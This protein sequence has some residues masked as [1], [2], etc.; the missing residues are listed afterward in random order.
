MKIVITANLRTGASVFLLLLA[1]CAAAQETAIDTTHL[2]H[3]DTIADSLRTPIVPIPFVGSIERRPLYLITDSTLNFFDYNSAGDLLNVVPGLFRY[4]LGSPG[5]LHGLTIDGLDNRNIAFMSDGILLNEP[6]TGTFNPY[7]YPT[8]NAERVEIITGTSAF[9]YGLNSTAGAVNFVSKNKKAIHP[10]TRIRYSEEPY[11]HGFI[12]GSFSQDIIRG[13]NLN[14]GAFHHTYEGRFPNSN[15]DH[16]NGRAKARYNI[17]NKLDL[18]ASGMYNQTNLGLNGGV[19]LSKTP[20]DFIFDQRNATLVNTDAYEKVTRYDLQAGAAAAL[21]SDTTATTTLT[22]FHS[23]NFREYRDEENRQSSNG[24]FVMEDDRSQW[25][26]IKLMQHFKIQDNPIDLGAEV[27][28]RG[29]IASDILGQNFRNLTSIFGKI[30]FQAENQIRFSPYSRIDN[31]LGETSIS[32]GGDIQIGFLDNMK[33]FGGYSHSYGY[34]TLEEQYLGLDKLQDDRFGWGAKKHQLVE[35]GILISQSENCSVSIR[36][37]HRT[38]DATYFNQPQGSPFDVLEYHEQVIREGIVSLLHVRLG[39]FLV[40]GTVQ[41]LTGTTDDKESG[42][43]PRWSGTGGFYFWDKLV[44]NHLDLKTGIR[45]KAFSSY[46]A[47]EFDQQN[48]IFYASSQQDISATGILDLV[49]IAHIGDAY[50]HLIMEN[51]LDRKYVTT[52][53]YPMPERHLRFGISWEFK[54]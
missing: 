18:F 5:Q 23:T 32:F 15:E 28:R 44:N 6:L 53:F 52:T 22:L 37:V 47:V 26:G 43:L 19:D 25:Y 42:N 35:G 39:S 3:A 1:Q 7:L 2:R 8:E 33:F 41:Y 20:N 40:E 49:V 34:P 14:V 11:G 10:Y 48:Q 54:D 46:Q 13:M 30:E 45:G 31:Y 50:V 36:A 27:Q 29:V 17:D 38:I 9:W 4:D 12:D 21:F 24:R 16:W 51:L